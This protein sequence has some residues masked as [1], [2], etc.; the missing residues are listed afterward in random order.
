MSLPEHCL[1]CW[2]FL[3]KMGSCP[4]P[5]ESLFW[6]VLST[7]PYLAAFAVGGLALTRRKLS[8]FV[9]FGIVLS[10]YL[11]ADIWLKNLLK[12]KHIFT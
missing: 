9:S 6:S 4:Y 1:A 7:I 8:Y 2:K 10:C 3:D 11:L 12:G 5:G